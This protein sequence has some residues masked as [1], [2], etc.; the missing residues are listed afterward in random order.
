LNS[1]IMVFAPFIFN[2]RFLKAV[3]NDISIARFLGYSSLLKNVC[4]IACICVSYLFKE[5]IAFRF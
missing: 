4:A 2:C 1:V 3:T 5:T